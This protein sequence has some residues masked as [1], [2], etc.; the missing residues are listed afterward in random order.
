[1]EIFHYILTYF[2]SAEGVNTIKSV[3]TYLASFLAIYVAYKALETWKKEFIGKKKID[4]AC[5]IIEQVC[6]IQDIIRHARNPVLSIGESNEIIKDLTINN[7]EIKENKLCC[8]AVKYRLNNK[9]E[10]IYNFFKLRNKAQLY[11]DDDILDLFN[12]LNKII[13]SIIA[14]AEYLYEYVDL[15]P[16]MKKACESKIWSDLDNNKIDLA[17]QKIVD[18]FKLNLRES[19][20]ERI[21][22][23]KK[24][25]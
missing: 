5:D 19:Y 25:K 21:T 17:V 23:W 11:W 3:L 6:N 10:E 8:F 18:E 14:A 16:E 2:S 12:K 1:M 4:L 20:K 13:T 22:K 24:L 9:K 7:E 15:D